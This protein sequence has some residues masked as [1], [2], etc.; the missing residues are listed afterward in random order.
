M[1]TTLPRLVVLYLVTA[2]IGWCDYVTG[3]ELD[4]FVLYFLPI[5]Y[6]AWHVGRRAGV[7]LA[8]TSAALWAGANVYLGH[9]YS[10][11]LLGVWGVLVFLATFVAVALVSSRLR[12]L[13]DHE[14]QLNGQLVEAFAKVKKL[15]G[16]LP[17]CIG[18]KSIQDEHG[19]WHEIEEYFTVQSE[20]DFVFKQSVCPHCRAE[21]AARAG[22]EVKKSSG[23]PV[24]VGGP[25]EGRTLG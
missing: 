16:R 1:K 5:A 19:G 12:L 9:A 10:Q 18:C 24:S 4:L 2:L 25:A 20:D 23:E 13:L 7:L 3:D 15:S 8:V 11:P 14:R 6:G 21:G 22:A 17:I